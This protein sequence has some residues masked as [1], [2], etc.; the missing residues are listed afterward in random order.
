[1]LPFTPEAFFANFTQYNL[2]IWPAQPIA[3]LLGLVVLALTLRP[4]AGGGRIIALV[5]A[6][7]WLWIGAVYHGLFFARIDDAASVFSIVSFAQGLLFVRSALR[8]D[9]KVRA[10]GDALGWLGLGLAVFAMAVYPLLGWLAGHGWPR[11]PMF[12]VAPCPT[13]IFTMGVLLMARPRAPLYLLPIPVLWSLVGGSASL[14]LGMPED[15]ALPIAGV[16]GFALILWKR[17]P[18]KAPA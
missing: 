12:G 7:A 1:M 3:Y 11:A 15:I 9:L 18:P 6:V 14:L 8:G 10:G 16:G 5:L 13:T 2:L 17:R 4:V